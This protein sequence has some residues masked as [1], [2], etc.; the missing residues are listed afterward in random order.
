MDKANIE[1]YIQRIK[2][3]VEKSHTGRIRIMEV[4]GTHTVSLMRTGVKSLLPKEIALIS[5]PG[6]PVCV[7]TQGY[8]DSA[9]EL[10]KLNDTIICTYGDMIR[11]P[12]S[13][14]SL[15]KQ[16]A[17]TS[18]VRVV[19]SARDAVTASEKCP[20]KN[21]VFLAVGFETTAPTT[22][23]A[24]MEAKRKGLKNFYIL[25]G[26]KLVIPAMRALLSAG[27]VGIDGFMCPG[28]VSVVIG[29]GAYLE[30]AE[31]FGK[32]CCVVGFEP[33][34]MLAGIA[35]LSEMIARK[36]FEVVN[37]YGAAVKDGGNAIARDM[38]GKVFEPVDC[39]WRA[40][41][42]IAASGLGLRKEYADF[43]AAVK[44]GLDIEADPKVPG[45]RCGE[46]IQGLIEPTVCGLFG[47]RCTPSN[48][49]GPCMVSS[50]GT[51]AAYFKYGN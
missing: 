32:P 12:G 22:A 5:G 33:G 45:C 14:T 13:V 27:E 39:N 35:E 40:M 46:V 4:C 11:V 41:G 26:H 43:D 42:T 16:K 36:R 15:E 34:Q 1:K 49:V 10:A 28:H 38:I 7:T 50:E 44:F 2:S 31:D 17:D 23:A 47:E 30:I 19:Y 37:V 24:V 8:I 18:D 29:P 3:A 48:P 51:C 25:C 21:V 6:C 9:C 20:Y